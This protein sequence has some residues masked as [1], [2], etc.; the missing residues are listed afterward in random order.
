MAGFKRIALVPVKDFRTA[1]SRLAGV[2]SLGERQTLA[3]WMFWRVLGQIRRSGLFSE[4][5]VLS[6][7]SLLQGSKEGFPVHIVEQ[8]PRL[9]LEEALSAYFLESPWAGFEHFLLPADLPLLS[10]RDFWGLTLGLRRD[11]AEALLVPSMDGRGTNG[12]YLKNPSGQ[13]LAFG[14]DNSLSVNRAM[15]ERFGV[16]PGTYYSLGFALDVDTEGDL[17]WAL[18]N[19]LPFRGL[20]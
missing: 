3:K 13:R 20:V 16:H 14:T 11:G 8:D 9:G 19:G 12:V 10:Q 7:G 17:L 1:K 15:L 4:A 18:H 5:V 6:R 2:L